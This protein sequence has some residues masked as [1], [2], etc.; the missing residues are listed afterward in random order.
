MNRRNSRPDVFYKKAFLRIFAIYT[1]KYLPRSLLNKAIGIQPAIKKRERL[2]HR[3]LTP[4]N[5]ANFLRFFK[6]ISGRVLLGKHWV[7]LKTAPVA[8]PVNVSNTAY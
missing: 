7:S 1:E 6:N 5:F 3:R 4:V 8:I 2:Q